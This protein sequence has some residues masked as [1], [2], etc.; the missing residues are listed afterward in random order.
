MVSSRTTRV[1]MRP[2]STTPDPSRD[3][4][5]RIAV[6]KRR[7]ST[8]AALQAAAARRY[9][10]KSGVPASD[11][12]GC[13]I[14]AGDLSTVHSAREMMLGLRDQFHYGEC[15]GCGSLQLLNVPEDLGRYYPADYY[16]LQPRPRPS[17]TVRLIRRLRAEAVAR[18]YDRLAR[19]IGR[20]GS[21]PEWQWWMRCAGM[22]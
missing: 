18:D 5:P 12:T 6:E 17:A 13:R 2:S 19:L 4:R 14:C 1:G 9:P 7:T 20:S 15:D 16:S 22:D 3:P 11:A 21:L 8:R 10:T